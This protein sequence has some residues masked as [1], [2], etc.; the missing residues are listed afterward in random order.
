[1]KGYML[2]NPQ[3]AGGSLGRHWRECVRR[4]TEILGFE[5]T[6]SLSQAPGDATWMVRRAIEEGHSHIVVFGGDGTLNEAVNGFFDEGRFVGDDVELVYCP[7]GTGGDFARSLGL[8]GHADVERELQHG[9]TRKIDVGKATFGEAGEGRSSSY[10]LNISS[11]GSSGLIARYVNRSTKIFGGK[12]SFYLGTVKGLARYRNSWVRLTLDDKIEKEVC[13]NTVAVANGRFFGGSMKIAPSA[14]LD[15]GWFDVVVLADLN[16]ADFIRHS[17]KLYQGT[18]TQ[19]AQVSTYRARKV[20]AMPLG[21]QSVLIDCDGEQPGAL[22]VSYEL[23]PRTLNL[24]TPAGTCAGV[25]C[26]GTDD[27]SAGD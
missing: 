11:F 25:F 1:M 6:S 16:L 7:F 4:G 26:S 23:L 17:R 27:A 19:L 20:E 3:A 8:G 21:G 2:G 5:P 9:I 22:P 10:F 13:I 14:Q 15:D 12:A 24:R 18:H